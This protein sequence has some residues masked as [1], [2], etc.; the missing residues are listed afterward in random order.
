[1][2]PVLT[3][4]FHCILKFAFSFWKRNFDCQVFAEHKAAADAN[5]KA[6]PAEELADGK[7]TAIQN[8][9]KKLAEGS[10]KASFVGEGCKITTELFNEKVDD[11]KEPNLVV[12]VEAKEVVDFLADVEKIE[13][14]DDAAKAQLKVVQDLVKKVFNAAEAK[15]TKDKIAVRSHDSIN[16]QKWFNYIWCGSYFC[17]DCGFSVVQSGQRNPRWGF[18]QKAA[19]KNVRCFGE[20]ARRRN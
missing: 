20:L 18:Q 19:R 17:F 16:N 8:E 10:A 15:A 6:Y 4:D 2:N 7:L 12:V 13:A 1:M 11:I 3:T 14:L 5:T 9:Y